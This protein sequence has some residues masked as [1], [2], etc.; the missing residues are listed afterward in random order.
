MR[1]VLVA[2]HN[3][4]SPRENYCF[5]SIFLDARMKV[6]MAPFLEIHMHFG[7]LH[8]ALHKENPST[9]KDP[10]N[11]KPSSLPQRSGLKIDAVKQHGLILGQDQDHI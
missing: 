2:T 3:F 10:Q 11:R 1:K 8:S 7:A 4:M 6:F 9:T 5:V